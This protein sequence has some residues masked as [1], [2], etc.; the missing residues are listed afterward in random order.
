MGRAVATPEDLKPLL[1]GVFHKWA[2]FAALVAVGV[3]VGV[4]GSATAR[5]AAIVYGMALAAMFGASA[6]YHR[7][8]WSERPRRWMRRLD[9]SAIF[10]MIAGTYTPFC[11]LVLSQPLGLIVLAVVWGGAFAAGAINFAW[12]DAPKWATAAVGIALGWISIVALPQ[13]PGLEAILL[14]IGGLF[15]TVG[16]LAYALKRPDPVPHVFGYHEVFHVL[17]VAAA[18][19]QFAAVAVAVAG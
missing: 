17:V 16:A 6:L 15:Y 1:R 2:F 3:L 9:H 5:A 12:I 4:A 13:M 8:N 10:L 19:V 11:L 7:I 18:A 14:G